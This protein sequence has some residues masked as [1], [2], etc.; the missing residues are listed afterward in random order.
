MILICVDVKGVLK[1]EGKNGK[2]T[3]I[4]FKLFSL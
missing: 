1:N 3:N 4:W 2:T